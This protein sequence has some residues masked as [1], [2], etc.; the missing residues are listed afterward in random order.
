MARSKWISFGA[1]QQL[2]RAA[3]AAATPATL[4][5]PTSADAKK[6]GL[7]NVRIQGDVSVTHFALP[8]SPLFVE[9]VVREHLVSH[10]DSSAMQYLTCLLRQLR[11]LSP[12]SVVL[13]HSIP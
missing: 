11:Q 3:K 10:H 8:I 7:E 13:L 2:E 12:A 1:Q 4:S 9:F 6:F 5:L